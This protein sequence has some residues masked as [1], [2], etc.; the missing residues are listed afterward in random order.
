MG[1]LARD[2]G[3]QHQTPGAP[4]GLPGQPRAGP[5]N[6]QTLGEL[7]DRSGRAGPPGQGRG[8]RGFIILPDNGEGADVRIRPG[9]PTKAV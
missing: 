9:R 2:H 3:R 8:L 6:G 7:V 4:A 1:R 5:G